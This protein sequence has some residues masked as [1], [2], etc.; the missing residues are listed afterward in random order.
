MS[1]V[2]LNI[3]SHAPEKCTGQSC[4]IHNPSDHHMKDWPMIMRDSTLIERQCP[5]GIGHPD[6]DSL[7]HFVKTGHEYLAIH[8]CDNC[9]IPPGERMED[10]K[11][12]RNPTPAVDVIIQLR[13]GGVVLI[14][15]K[16]TPHGWALPGGYVDEGEALWQAALREAKEE[17]SLDV[18][19]VEQFYTY[20]DPKRDPRKHM[21]STVYIAHVIGGKMKAADD[22]KHI[23]AFLK[24]ELPTNLVFDHRSILEDYYTYLVT[25]RRP[26]FSR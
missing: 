11:K 19:L 12:Y 14:E 20:S 22:A 24:N 5:H 17:T 25:G 18:G 15:R 13:H 2:T 23:A 3:K 1:K 8:G 26:G 6:P 10:E 7:A 4:V 16:N 9:C 21:M